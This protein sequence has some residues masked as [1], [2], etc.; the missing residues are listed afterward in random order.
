M[1]STIAGPR[2][3]MR[4]A[5]VDFLRGLSLFMIY[6]DHCTGNFFGYFT[7]Q[8]LQF[9]DASQIFFALSGFSCMAAYGKK[10]RSSGVFSC[11]PAIGRKCF[12]IYFAQISVSLLAL[13]IVY[14]WKLEWP[15]FIPGTRSVDAE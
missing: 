11:F 13:L 14:V 6:I 4:D 2:R 5:R 9:S 8:H 1:P 7:L 15:F 10:I 3:T 12:Q